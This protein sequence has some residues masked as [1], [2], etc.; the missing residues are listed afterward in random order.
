VTVGSGTAVAFGGLDTGE[1]AV[2]D[3]SAATGDAVVIAL[4]Q[5]AEFTATGGAGKLTTITN[6]ALAAAGK[7]NVTVNAGTG[8]LNTTIALVT[9]TAS[10]TATNVATITGS[11]GKDTIDITSVANATDLSATE[12]DE[13]KSVT[14]VVTAGGGDDT[15]K[16]DAGVV[17]VDAGDGDDRVEFTTASAITS[18]DSV[19]GGAGS[20]TIAVASAQSDDLAG[21]SA[22]ARAK[23]TGFE[24]LAITDAF[25]DLVDASALSVNYLSLEAGLSTSGSSSSTDGVSGLTSGA[26]IQLGS[27]AAVTATAANAGSIAVGITGAT[28]AGANS[29]VLNVVLKSDIDVASTSTDV[30]LEVGTLAI[31]GVDTVNID[32]SDAAGTTAGA[33][34]SQSDDGYKISFSSDAALDK[35]IVTGSRAVQAVI[36]SA[37]TGF[38]EFDGSAATGVLTFDASAAT[39]VNAV[40][41]KGGADGDTLTGGALADSITANDGDDNVNGLAGNDVINLGAGADTVNGGTGADALTLGA[42]KDTVVVVS[43]LTAN[44]V[45]ETST[46]VASSFDKVADF[47]VATASFTGSSANDTVAE[48][49]ALSAG[50]TETD[51][52]DFTLVAAGGTAVALTVAGASGTAGTTATSNVEVSA[53]GKVTF[54]AADDTLA[55]QLAAVKADTTDVDIGE[56]VFWE[57]GGNTYVFVNHGTNDSF[58]ELTGVTGVAGLAG[59]ASSGTIGGANYIIIA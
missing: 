30:L 58:V 54:A 47:K 52:L 27:A 37:A 59:L 44:A 10:A 32:A 40:T 21:L 11:A 36:S 17:N 28:A 12:A 42:G 29:D 43:D 49:V 25:I 50:G 34:D 6:T 48:F 39:T 46:A 5:V 8:A 35:I 53:T 20:D 7:N 45:V 55:E 23:L 3:A 41:I 33:A 26:T 38:A 22:T 16:I 56:A 15:I 1:K 13:A 31:S 14:A 19:S 57:N 51:I 24:K 2:V 4:G 18:S 9:N